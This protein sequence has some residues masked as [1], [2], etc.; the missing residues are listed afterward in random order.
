MFS[1]QYSI[2]VKNNSFS[3]KTCRPFA[4]DTQHNNCNGFHIYNQISVEF[5]TPYRP[6]V[7]ST[8]HPILGSNS[9][10]NNSCLSFVNLFSF[11]IL[12]KIVFLNKSVLS[13][14]YI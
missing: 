2:F 12:N 11:V 7:S 14:F 5:H 10:H 3:L 6:V 8:Q 1:T 4:A 13:H 9:Q